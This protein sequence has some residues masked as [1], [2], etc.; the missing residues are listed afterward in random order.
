[1]NQ[2]ARTIEDCIELLGDRRPKKIFILIDNHERGLI[3]SLAKQV[4]NGISLTDRQLS[5]VLNKIEKYR[6]GLENNDVDVDRILNE[7]LLRMPLREID[8]NQYIRFSSE[9]NKNTIKIRYPFSKKIAAIW[10]ELEKNLI[11]PVFEDWNDKFAKHVLLTETNIELIL[12]NFKDQSF[13]IDES[14][15]EKYKEIKKIR[16]SI[17]SLKPYVDFIDDK[18]FIKNVDLR[19]ETYFHEY[20]QKNKKTP[21]I[22]VVKAKNLGIFEKTDSLISMIETLSSNDLEKNILLAPN[23]RFNI[24]PESNELENLIKI[25][26]NLEQWPVL[27]V[28]DENTDLYDNIKSLTRILKKFLKE[29]QFT[30]FFRMSQSTQKNQEFNQFI[31]DNRL[32]NYIDDKIKA[33]AILKNKIPK[34][35]IKSTWKPSTALVLSSISSGKLSAYLNDFENVYYYNNSLLNKYSSIL[36]NTKVINV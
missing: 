3:N 32:N 29:D 30:V 1:M 33:V 26:D 18:V 19:C 34:P 6:E 8:R 27:F 23:N 9:N 28:L 22:D 31:K 24:N 4:N 2:Q 36:T 25:I 17:K 7:K 16:N 35:L 12:D 20:T 13:E 21:L 10:S 5:L 11:G 15:R 14:I